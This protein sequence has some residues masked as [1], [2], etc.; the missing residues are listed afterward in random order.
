[1]TK[2]RTFS[3]A[4]GALA[5]WLAGA[6]VAS[7][8]QAALWQALRDGGHVALIRH[9]LAPGTGDPAGLTVGDCSTQRNLSEV[10]RAQAGRIGDRFRA[11]GIAQAAVFTSQWCR[12]RDTADLMGLGDPT[13]LPALNSFHGRP[14]RR[15]PQMAALES[16]LAERRP[17][18]P[19]VLVTHQVVIA[20]ATGSYASSGEMVVAKWLPGGNLS[21]IGTIETR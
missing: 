5:I 20:A 4:I 16:W 18:G 12:C 15:A 17:D 9:A 19:M 1:M 13:E 7:A 6:T 21:V 10:G 2:L 3:V 11:N 8:E 14:E